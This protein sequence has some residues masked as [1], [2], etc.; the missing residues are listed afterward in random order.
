MYA[1]ATLD[2]TLTFRRSC[3]TPGV[4]R[5]DAM[6]INGVNR[7]AYK[8]LMRDLLPAPPRGRSPRLRSGRQ[9]VD[10]HHR[11][12]PR[13]ARGRTSVVDVEPFFDAYRAVKPYLITSGNAPPR[14]GSSPRPTGALRRHHQVHPVRLLHHELPGVLE[15][16]ATSDRRRS[17]MPTGSS[18]TVE[19]KAPPNDW[20]SSTRSTAWR[21]RTTFN[22]T[23]ACPRGIEVKAIQS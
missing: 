1:R 5:S 23:D 15:R 9:A 12:H 3:A 13:P 4:C 14:S 22:C 18:S 11:A 17:S 16:G 10:H 8:V 20:R 6:R 19:T 2:G 7:L 21:C